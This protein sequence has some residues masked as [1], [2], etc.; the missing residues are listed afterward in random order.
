MENELYHYGVK[1][2][3][4]GVRKKY[5]QSSS[6][7][8]SRK[9]RKQIKNGE[10]TVNAFKKAANEL[11]DKADSDNFFNSDNIFSEK[12][13][14][15]ASRIRRVRDAINS[16][17]YKTLTSSKGKKHL[18]DIGRKL[19]EDSLDDADSR[20]FFNDD[21]NTMMKKRDTND[22]IRELIKSRG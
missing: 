18:T 20:S 4:W 3:L 8:P 10:K 12:S 16:L 6:Q 7:R 15:R 1:G 17:D 9:T 2:M 21:W 22:T 13:M 19:V 5:P 11:L 14:K